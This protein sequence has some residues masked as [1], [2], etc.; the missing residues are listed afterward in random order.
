VRWVLE[1]LW[2]LVVV[3][4][5]ALGVWMA[6]SLAAYRNGPVWLAVACGLLLFPILPVAWEAWARRRLARARRDPSRTFTTWDRVV[7]RT[8]VVN[9]LFMGTL[10]AGFPA[11]TFAALSTR[12][13]WFL[14]GRRDE[15]AEKARRTL[16]AAAGALEWLYRAVRRN[17]Y[18]D[19]LER[20]AQDQPSP[21]P[22]PV[23]RA[24]AEPEPPV[25]SPQPPRRGR[26][27]PP[28]PPPPEE[29][30][31]SADGV[32]EWPLPERLHPAVLELPAAAETRIA[33][34]GRYLAGREANPWLRVKALHDYVADRVAYDVESYRSR[35]IPPQ[36]A[37]TVF[38]TRRSV[39]AGYANLLAALGAAAGETIVVIGGDARNDGA[40]LTGEGHAWNAAR[41]GGRWALVDATWDAG[42]VNG[43]RFEKDY[44]TAYLF[45]PPEVQGVTHFPEEE[46]WQL[47]T[48][49][50]SR[51]EFFR[52]P[53]M[54]AGFFAEGL[55][56]VAPDRSQVTV[57]GALDVSVRNPRQRWLMAHFDDGQ[58][59]G[60][61]DCAVDHGALSALRCAFPGSGTYR[62]RLFVGREQ[63]GTYHGV[64]EIEAH[65]R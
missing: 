61:G 23:A 5:P 39:C 50:L 11:A 9:L 26:P 47:R 44:G 17:P 6:S 56:L 65:S 49:P 36:D 38:R 22:A 62:V 25:A 58:G 57:D 7:L 59:G 12:G 1:A 60:R 54:K 27:L 20:R 42:S 29:P 53:M 15:E 34:V 40:D 4:V 2:V 48:P 8:L 28:T 52:Q 3:L 24:S 13:D 43:D 33:D 31:F 37:E 14:Q 16:F 19:V 41:I 46:Q 32:P 63:Y 51:G 18:D 10:V 21:E 30:R 55:E 45:A 64:G 35:K